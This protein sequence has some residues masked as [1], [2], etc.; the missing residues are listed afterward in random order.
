MPP[1]QGIKGTAQAWQPHCS[2]SPDGNLP[3]FHV[4]ESATTADV[5]HNGHLIRLQ[6]RTSLGPK[7]TSKAIASNMSSHSTMP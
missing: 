5:A 3:G 4:W 2:G 7:I 6:I 1:A